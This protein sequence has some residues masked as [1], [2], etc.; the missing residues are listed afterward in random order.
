MSERDLGPSWSNGPDELATTLQSSVQGL[1][2][3]QADARLRDYGPNA[4]DALRPLSRVRG[5]L[6]QI[7]SPR[8]DEGLVLPR[9][10]LTSE[11]SLTHGSRQ[12]FG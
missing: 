5:L 6:N 11:A 10:S 4:L 1:T 8:A 9:T 2:S 12:G 3:T 7:R